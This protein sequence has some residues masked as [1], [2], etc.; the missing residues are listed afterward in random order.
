MEDIV[1]EK[2]NNEEIINKR[3]EK[4]IKV[5][6]AVIAFLI[7]LVI[8]IIKA[9]FP[10]FPTWIF[11]VISS[12]VVCI[13]LLIYFLSNITRWWKTRIKEGIMSNEKLPKAAEL[14]VLID[15]A[16]SAMTNQLSA[17]MLSPPLNYWYES[18]GKTLKNK[19]F[20]YQAKAVYSENMKRGI[21]YVLLNVHDP[22][23]LRAILIDPSAG[24]LSRK[25]HSLS[26]TD[27]EEEPEERIIERF[28]STTGRTERV[29]E[30]LKTVIDNK[31]EKKKETNEGEVE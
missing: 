7:L 11:I 30:K 24:E 17:N 26:I 21:V 25:I 5:W 6:S 20:V 27:V 16:S 18:V 2:K 3:N 28:D 12:V 15:I 13:A 9:S 10:K 19:V 31:E 22:I 4:V 23:N 14:G 8:F 1:E 29:T